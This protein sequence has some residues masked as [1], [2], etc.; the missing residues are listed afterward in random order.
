TYWLKRICFHLIG[1]VG[2]VFSLRAKLHIYSCVQTCVLRGSLLCKGTHQK[3]YLRPCHY[4]RDR[5]SRKKASGLANMQTDG[6][7][8][9]AKKHI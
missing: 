6:K 8:P 1:F 2:G 7:Y 4:G 5:S 3:V 9:K